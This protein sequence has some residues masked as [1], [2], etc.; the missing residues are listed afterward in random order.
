MYLLP[1]AFKGLTVAQADAGF[2]AVTCAVAKAG[3]AYL[4]VKFQRI[5][6]VKLCFVYFE[7]LKVSSNLARLSLLDFSR[8]RLKV[9]VL[10]FRGISPVNIF[11]R[12]SP[13]FERSSSFS[14]F[15]V[16]SFHL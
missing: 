11:G 2:Y 13:A 10:A 5:G 1:L 3:A 16:G 15:A 7:A 6:P 12:F 14:C 4:V 8:L 9:Q